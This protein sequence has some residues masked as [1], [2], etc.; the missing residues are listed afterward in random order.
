MEGGREEK[1]CGE[2]WGAHEVGGGGWGEGQEAQWPQAQ[3]SPLAHTCHSSLSLSGDRFITRSILE[4]TK[5]RS[6]AELD[7]SHLGCPQ[8]LGVS[9][10]ELE[11]IMGD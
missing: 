6:Q 1:S 2:G 8:R 10:S 7:I 11:K 4:F 3:P 5:Q 9:I